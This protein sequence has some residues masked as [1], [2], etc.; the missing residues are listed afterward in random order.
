MND[1][2]YYLQLAHTSKD[3]NN[4]NN[5]A[6]NNTNNNIK[7]SHHRYVA[8]LVAIRLGL[9]DAIIDAAILYSI[10]YSIVAGL[11]WNDTD[12][13]I[14]YIIWGVSAI[15]S[16]FILA[17]GGLKIPQWM[18]YYHK[19]NLQFL[20]DTSGRAPSAVRT[21]Q[22]EGSQITTDFQYKVRLG[23]GKHF[24]S[25]ICYL[26]PFYV[27]L[28]VWAL[29]ISITVGIAF[30]LVYLFVLHKCKQRYD[31][32]LGRVAMGASLFLCIVRKVRVC[33]S[34]SMCIRVVI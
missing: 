14:V 26:L 31:M 22:N 3:N 24:N 6:N 15:T 11:T 30:G 29:F 19:S 9:R 20:T 27:N 18:G 5:N 34:L 28:K 23:I 33:T 13:N 32:H 12:P 4:D 10:T 2:R 1:F 21:L 7:I 17:V 16:A 25:F 8:S